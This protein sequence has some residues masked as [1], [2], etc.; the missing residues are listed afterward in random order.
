MNHN[1]NCIFCKIVAGEL[2]A[3]KV[4]SD[5][6]FVVFKDVK[7]IAPVHLL[8]VPRE[9]IIS[10]NELEEQHDGLIAS[11]MRVLPKL[12]KQQGLD[13]GFRTVI[14]TGPGGGQVVF[15]LHIHLLGGKDLASAGFV[16]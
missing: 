14:N 9:H 12:A 5:E 2:P 6:Q 8:L 3:E 13:N 16:M 4:Y 7:P 15:H 1:P 10:L 11:M